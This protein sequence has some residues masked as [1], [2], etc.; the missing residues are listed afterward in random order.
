MDADTLWSAMN[1]TTQVPGDIWEDNV[2]S[3]LGED[4]STIR[5]K[6]GDEDDDYGLEAPWLFD[7][8]LGDEPEHRPELVP[9]LHLLPTTSGGITATSS[10]LGVCTGGAG[11]LTFLQLWG[12]FSGV[13]SF[14]LLQRV[15]AW[16]LQQ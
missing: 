9:S 10:S 6:F 12:Y 5:S 15:M 3:P 16:P 1:G 2:G 4:I 8:V 7:S 14:V 13:L 11:H